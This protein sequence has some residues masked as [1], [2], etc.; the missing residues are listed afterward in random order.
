MTRA[1]GSN[2]ELPVPDGDFVQPT[3]WYGSRAASQARSRV[4][5]NLSVA[6][7]PYTADVRQ[8]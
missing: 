3:G 2:P 5:L 8:Q 6:A 4:A 1:C 7:D